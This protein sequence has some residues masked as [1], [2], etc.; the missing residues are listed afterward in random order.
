MRIA[1]IIIA[2]LLSV[3]GH[4]TFSQ[5]KI[6][7]E[8]FTINPTFESKSVSGI[9]WMNNG[10]FYTSLVD[11]RV[12]KFDITTGE[13]V[14]TVFNGHLF[15]ALSISQYSFS[16]NEDKLLIAS[17]KKSIYRRSY[18]AEYFVYDIPSSNLRKLSPNGKQSYATFSPDGSK[19]GF[20]RS[21][22]LFYV[23]LADMS[24]VQVTTDGNFNTII[25]GTTDWVYE[26]EFGFVEAFYWSPDSK[27][28][29][30]YRFD[31]TDVRE[32][33]LQIWGNKLYPKDY[34]FKYP[35]AGETNSTVSVWV[36]SLESKEKTRID[37]GEEKD[38]YIPRVKWT[39][40][41]GT[42]SVRRLNRLQNEQALLHADVVTGKSNAVITEKSKTYIDV[43]FVDDLIYLSDGRHFVYTS[44]EEGYKH[45]YLYG[46]DG[47]KKHQITSG[48]FEVT[49]L[50][51]LNEK[52]RTLYYVSTEASPLE[53]QFYSIQLDGKKKTRLS[54]GAGQHVISMSDDFQ[55]YID[56]YNSASSPTVVSLFRT[57]GNK[58]VK[59]LEEN[60]D[61]KSRVKEYQVADKEFFSFAGE[62]GTQL[63]GYLL[64]PSNFEEG[65]KYPLILYQYS[66]PG[67]QNAGNTW[68][69]SHFYFHQLLTAEGFIIAVVDPRGTGGRG[70][71]FKKSTYKQLGKYELDDL[72]AAADYLGSLAYVDKQRLGI[73]GWSYGGYMAS[74]AMTKAAG[75]FKAGIAVSPVTNWRFYDTIYTE[76]YLQTPQL[77]PSGYDDN[78]PLSH[79][80]KLQ[81]ELLLIHGT[82]DDNVHLQNSILFQNALIHAGKQFDS[83]YY[84]DKHHGIQGPKVR[85]HLYTQMLNFFKANL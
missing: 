8:D 72:V 25:N 22:N 69:G 19:I 63:N 37:I 58:L 4:A 66:G 3:C 49:T 54:E 24:E 64:K 5:K 18:L 71:E 40:D 10:K 39:T 74:L 44:E 82:G 75:V 1:R 33:N 21:N 83:F 50:I 81:G 52:T 53:R 2:I 70:A 29:A 85:H 11:N 32:Y 76:R 46:M 80:E 43:E 65:K 31:E 23:N 56:H 57:K 26:E 77:N 14:D 48:A 36:Y 28:I 84:P 60:T 6:S 41:P 45:L 7:V 51:G 79:A 27:R 42:L 68:A 59:V 20:V 13:V 9:N 73:W 38:I 61:L 35:K 55:F 62:G 17:D 78:S 47:S 30:F 15:P 12:F 34:R 67:S 16:E